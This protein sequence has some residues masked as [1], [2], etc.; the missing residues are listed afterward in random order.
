[1]ALPP[2]TSIA[3]PL[4][5]KVWSESESRSVLSDSL[6]AH[7]PYSPWDSPS[8]DTGVGGLF[9]LQGIFPIQGL[10]PRPSHGRHKLSHK[11][12]SRVCNFK[13]SQRKLSC[14][15]F[16]PQVKRAQISKAMGMMESQMLLLTLLMV[17]MENS[18]STQN[19]QKR[20]FN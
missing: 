6:R 15:H 16:L 14:H 11:G 18:L 8:Q 2:P 20:T 5:L 17:K 9:L 4:M 7:G 12:S 10:T 3:L 1:M 19:R 13:K